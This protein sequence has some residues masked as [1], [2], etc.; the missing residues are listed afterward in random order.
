MIK[1]HKQAEKFILSQGKTA[2]LRLYRAIEG[3]PLGDVQ[4][5]R[6]KDDPPLYRLRVGNYRIVFCVEEDNVMV[7]RIDSRGDV[8]KHI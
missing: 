6:G 4:R 3:L 7:L 1:Y 2:A 8:Y 5:L